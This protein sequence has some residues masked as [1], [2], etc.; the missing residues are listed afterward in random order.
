MAVRRSDGAEETDKTHHRFVAAKPL[1]LSHVTVF[2]AVS[3]VQHVQVVP[4]DRL[5]E[6]TICIYNH[7]QYI[8]TYYIVYI[9]IYRLCEKTLVCT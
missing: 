2:S 6:N 4:V 8:Y 3:S 5:C 9:Y 1:Q 7:I